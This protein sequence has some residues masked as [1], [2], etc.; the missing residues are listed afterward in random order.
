MDPFE[1]EALKARKALVMVHNEPAGIL[2]MS[3]TDEYQFQYLDEYRTRTKAPVSLRMPVRKEPYIEESLHPFFDNLLFEGEQLRIFEKTYGLQRQSKVDRFK[4]LMLTGQHTLSAVSVV[5]LAGEKPLLLSGKEERHENLK[6]FEL[7]PAY[8]DCCSICLKESLKGDHAACK[9]ALW[10]TQRIIHMEA[11]SEDPGNIFRA[12]RLGQSISGAQR[13][14]LFHLNQKKILTREGFPQYI[15]KPDGEFPEMP[16]NEHLT[17]SIARELRFPVPSMA[18]Y[19]VEGIGLVYVIKR[20]DWSA[21][22]GFQPIEDLAQLNQEL[23]ERKNDGTLEQLAQTITKF[24]HSPAIELADFFRRILFCF[25][26]GNGDMHQKNWS[27]FRDSISGFHKLAPLYDYLNVRACF[28]QEQVETVLSLNGKQKDLTAH[29][30]KAF[31]AS[32]GINEKYREACF[33]ELIRWKATI[34]AFLERSALSSEMKRRYR[35]VVSQRIGR[36]TA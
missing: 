11:F 32:I 34:E 33:G 17:M 8:P 5:A 6:K 15:L 20:F 10:G 13:K 1:Q 18:L 35:D 12:I 7:T 31:S 16:A 25:V 4:L 14:A 24:T 19:R 27:I 29:D 9:K 21:T 36:L 3:A 22:K 28:P 23:A 30:F 2:T 26:I